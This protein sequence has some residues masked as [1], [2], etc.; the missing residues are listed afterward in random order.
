[1]GIATWYLTYTRDRYVQAL[2]PWLVV[3]AAVGLRSCYLSAAPLL[4]TAAVLLVATQLVMSADVFFLR[5]YVTAEGQHPLNDLM[6]K[7]TE[8]F[9]PPPRDA[10]LPQAGWSMAPWISLGKLL[11]PGAKLLVHR[12]RLWA[13]V[14]A[15]VVTDESAWQAGIDYDRLRSGK[16]LYRRLRRLGVTHVVTGDYE[17]SAELGP[18]TVGGE[19]VLWD[20]LHE[21]QQ[22]PWKG[23]WKLWRLPAAL[24][25]GGP[26][27]TVAWN[28]CK[29]KETA[30]GT[31]TLPQL[32]ALHRSL[33]P[34]ALPAKAQ[35]IRKVKPRFAVTEKGCPRPARAYVRFAKRDSLQLWWLPYSAAR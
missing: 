35:R 21:S 1:V 12:Q 8:G 16:A 18:A 5:S 34:M 3:V 7:V 31:Y 20:L 10:F 23:P 2:L 11:P 32:G 24:P 9:K 33:M 4:R 29:A 22:V 13:G 6:S 27:S 19:L 28:T 14:D 25:D 15:P 26:P 17:Y 30:N